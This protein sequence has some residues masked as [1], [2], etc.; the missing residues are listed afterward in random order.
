M[1]WKYVWHM[2]KCVVKWNTNLWMNKSHMNFTSYYKFVC[3]M[4]FQCIISICETYELWI[5]KFCMISI[6]KLWD[7]K[8]VI[9]IGD[10]IVYWGCNRSWNVK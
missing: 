4:C 6:T 2:D 8:F 1:C 10:A 5:N 3:Q 9:Q 7:A